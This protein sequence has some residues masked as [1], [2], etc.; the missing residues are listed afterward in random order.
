M[1]RPLFV[2][3]AATPL[4]LI[5]A[6]PASPQEARH[7]PPPPVA[8]GTPFDLRDMVNARAGPPAEAEIARR[9]YRRTRVSAGIAYWQKDRDRSCAAITTRN[10]KYASIVSR[11]AAE[12][13]GGPVPPLPG[14]RPPVWGK[15]M[16]AICWGRGER[17]GLF[18]TNTDFD[19]DERAQSYE[20]RG[21]G[22]R[23]L[24]RASVQVEIRNGSG[25]I[26]LSGKLLPTINSGGHNGWW[27]LTNIRFGNDRVTARYRLNLL[28]RPTVTIDRRARTI[29][30]RGINDYDG[31][32]EFGNWGIGRPH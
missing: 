11:P 6:A 32:C 31:T 9:G 21:H 4:F 25:R 24:M 27:P 16:T 13:R 14:P 28:H 22:D 10:G 29:A 19:W 20:A 18:S 2:C 12:C 8:S 23:N 3:V 17:P 30:I 1:R 7:R 15:Q 26:R 5:A